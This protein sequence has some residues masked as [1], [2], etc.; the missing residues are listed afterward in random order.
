MVLDSSV[1]LIIIDNGVSASNFTV[2]DLTRFTQLRLLKVGNHC[3]TFVNELNITGLNELE[4]VEMGENSFT[5][6]KNWYGEDRNRHF[7]LKDCPKLRSLKIGDYSFS[8]YTVF[9]IE[10]VDMLE[11]IEMGEL[12][13]ESYNFFY[14]S[15]ELRSILIH[16]ELRLDMPS[17]KS[18]VIGGR[19][20]CDCSR[21]V[22]ESN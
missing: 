1:N 6:K 2:L 4:R 17:L 18:L 14:A 8:D 21:V 3:F 16:S 13:K 12:N 11:V 5:K 20:F 10:N 15:L 9:E 7:Y 22:F 19:V